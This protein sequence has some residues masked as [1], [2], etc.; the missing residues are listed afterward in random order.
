MPANAQYDPTPLTDGN[1]LLA[2]AQSSVINLANPTATSLIL[3][4]VPAME[5]G[6]FTTVSVSM[7]SSELIDA[8]VA[9]AVRA[10]DIPNW[11]YST[12]TY[13][14]NVAGLM[15]LYASWT[16]QGADVGEYFII[17]PE[18][19][20]NLLSQ[21][22]PIQDMWVNYE[23]QANGFEGASGLNGIP[24]VQRGVSSFLPPTKQQVLEALPQ[25]TSET[26][27]V[28][29]TEVQPPPS[30]E[31]VKA[32]EDTDTDKWWLAAGVGAAALAGYGVFRLVKKGRK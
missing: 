26:E 10:L 27:I 19:V 4:A 16:R 29:Y 15:A 30:L 5:P 32:G 28:D 6:T 17:G 31:Q 3:F 22:Q 23:L 25:G 2:A 21:D 14:G 24:L 13:N 1:Q 9:A 18:D 20:F 12:G 11:T 7:P 8:L